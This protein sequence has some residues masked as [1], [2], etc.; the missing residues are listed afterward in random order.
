MFIHC[1]LDWQV[2]HPVT[3]M[4][5]GQDLVEWQIRVAN[6]EVLPLQQSEIKLMGMKHNTV[7]E[8]S[9]LLSSS[10]LIPNV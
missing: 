5:T 10:I 6:G 9:L 4:V 2:E 3:E 7:I 1:L 8:L